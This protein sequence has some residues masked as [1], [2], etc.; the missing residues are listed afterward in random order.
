MQIGKLHYSQQ[1]ADGCQKYK[2]EW[3]PVKDSGDNAQNH[4][5][6]FMVERGNCTFVT[7][8]RNIAAAGGAVALV[9]DT[10]EVSK[11]I[12]MSDDGTGAGIRIPSLLIPQK[13]GQILKDF[14]ILQSPGPFSES[15]LIS[16]NVEFVMKHPGD[17][18]KASMWYTSSDD[19]S[20]DFIKNMGE[21]LKP[22]VKEMDFKPKFVTWTCEGCDAD[23][24]KENCLSNGKYCALQSD[25]SNQ[26]SGSEIIME[27]LRQ[28]CLYKALNQ[29]NKNEKFFDYIDFVHEMC[30]SRIDEKC[31]KLGV[32]KI[33]FEQK[34][35]DNCVKDSFE[36]RGNV[37]YSKDEN[38]YLKEMATEW[39]NYGTHMYPSVVV[40]DVTFRGQLNPDNVFEA[41]CAGFED[42]PEGCSKWFQKEGFKPITR[43][44]KQRRGI[45]TA[46]LIV[47]ISLLLLVN[48]ALIWGYRQCLQTELQ[49][50]MKI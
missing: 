1:N 4:Q 10:K 5:Y 21:Y 19:K 49:N 3:K 12:V 42:I 34:W 2:N 16:L 43:I 50:D 48:G 9:M 15:H 26:I 20:L 40:N 47:I 32:K 7:K 39:H 30:H 6:I 23:F 22:I 46:S 41:I 38:N 17:Y 14:Y 37:E 45:S 36:N 8:A 11:T 25:M 28:Y 27:D 18:V 31:S 33:G 24:K 44:V 13:E 35:V 29:K